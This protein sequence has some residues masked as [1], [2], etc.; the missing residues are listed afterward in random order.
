MALWILFQLLSVFACDLPDLPPLL[1]YFSPSFENT[2]HLE[3]SGRFLAPDESL[4]WDLALAEDSWIRLS[5]EPRLH[6]LK[7]SILKGSNTMLTSSAVQEEFLMISNKLGKG[8]YVIIVTAMNAI[9][10]DETD[11]KN[12]KDCNLPNLFF[13]IAVHPYANLKELLP[14]SLE[15][16]AEGFPDL[17]DVSDTLQSFTPYSGTHSTYILDTSKIEM[18]DSVL[19]TFE[20]TNPEISQELK[21][22]GLTGLWKITFSLHYDFLT[23]GGMGLLFSKSKTN[24]TKFSKLNC[25]KRGSCLFGRRVDK[26]AVTVYSGFGAGKFAITV[27]Y[28]GMTLAEH[29]ML[30][31]LGGKIPFSLHV[32]IEPIIQREDRFNCE[33]AHI[34]HSLNT[35]GLMD[36]NGFLRYSDRVIADFLNVKQATEFEIS[37]PSVLRVITVEP[38]GID[39]DISLK[40]SQGIEIGKSN[41]IGESEGILKELQP[42]KYSIEFGVLNSVINDPR[43]KFCETF[44]LE[45]GISPNEAVRGFA[46]FLGM[47]ACEDNTSDL[48]DKFAKIGENLNST[49]SKVDL[50]STPGDFFRVPLKSVAKGEEVVFQS[51]FY[52]PIY[53]YCYFDIYSDF[54]I[55]DFTISLEKRLPRENTEIVKGDTT[56][57]LKLGKHDRRS[58]QGALAPGTYI[59]SIK[60][61]PTSKEISYTTNDYENIDS[62]D[63]YK[64]LPHCGAFQLRGKLVGTTET[65]LKKWPCFQEDAQLFPPTLNTLDKLGVKDTPSDYL[66][67][68]KVFIPNMMAPNSYTNATNDIAFY[69]NSESFIR[70]AAESEGS[71]MR[72]ALMMGKSTVI[73]D[74]APGERDVAIYGFNQILKQHQTYRLVISYY[75]NSKD[76]CHTYSLLIE[77]APISAL[78]AGSSQNCNVKLPGGEIMTERFLEN[79]GPIL[80]GF[81]SPEGYSQLMNENQYE[82]LQSAKP[83]NIEIP[84]KITTDGALLTGHI[85]SDFLQSGLIL[86]VLKEKEILEYGSF[87]ASHRFELPAFPLTQGEYTLVLK[88]SG[89]SLYKSCVK[90]S[91][92]IIVEDLSLWDDIESMI[93]KSETCSYVDQPGSLNLVGQIQ[94]GNLHWHKEL[95]LDVLMGATL[96]DFVID[97]ESIIRVFVVPQKE[98]TFEINLMTAESIVESVEKATAEEFSSGLH[99]KIKPGSYLLEISY[100]S[101]AALPSRRLCPSFEMDLQIISMT[102]FNKITS[103]YQCSGPASLPSVFDAKTGINEFSIMHN[104]QAIDHSIPLEF[105]KDSE[106]EAIV[107]FENA[108]SGFISLELSN[109]NGVVARSLGIEN[110]SELIVDLEKGSYILHIISSHGVDIPNACWP[111][112]VSIKTSD[113]SEE[114]TCNGGELPPSLTSKHSKVFGGPQARDGSISFHGT[115]KIKDEISSEVLKIS[116]P[117]SGIAR[118]MTISN[119]PKVIIESAVYRDS[120]FKDPVA[121]SRNKSNIGSYIFVIKA[122]KTPYYLLLTYIKDKIEDSCVT[123]DLKIVIETTEEVENILKCKVTDHDLSKVLPKSS[124]DFTKEKE[125]YG[126]DNYVI[127]DKWMIGEKKSFP[128]GITSDGTENSNFMYEM[129]INI[130][131]KAIVSIESTYDFLTNDLNMVLSKDDEQISKS[132]W[133]SL[134][135]D[136]TGELMNFASIIENE[137]LEP[138]QYKLVLKQ[139]VASNHLIQRYKDIDSCFPFSFNIEYIPVF[140]EKKSSS[141]M[142]TLADPGHL[143]HHNPNEELTILI[144]FDSPIANAKEVGKLVSLES[145]QYE[146]IT[147]GSLLIS[148]NAPNKIKFKFDASKLKESTC[149]QLKIDEKS[150]TESGFQL[151]SDGIKHSYCTMSCICN[152]KA[153]AICNE[154]FKCVCPE[155]YTGVTCHECVAG[156]TPSEGLCIKD[157]I[158]EPSTITEVTINVSSPM[159]KDELLNIFVTFSSAPHNSQKNKI[160]AVKNNKVIIDS[161]YIIN[162]LNQK[163]AKASSAAP[164]NKGETKWKFEFD[165]EDLAY[166]ASYS[167][168]IAKGSLFDDEGNEFQVATSLPQFKVEQKPNNPT[169]I[170]PSMNCGPNGRNAILGKCQCDEGYAGDLCDKCDSSYERN[171]N[172]KCE[173]IKAP[174]VVNPGQPIEADPNAIVISITPEG[175]QTIAEDSFSVAIELSQQAYTNEGLIID[176]LTNSDIIAKAFVLQKLKSKKFIRPKSAASLDKKGLRWEFLFSKADLEAD[177]TYKFVQV[178]GVLY[179]NKGKIFSA[180]TIVPPTF[181][182]EKGEEG[183]TIKCSQHGKINGSICIC[184]EGYTGDGCYD[185]DTG[186]EKTSQ[187]SCIM[188]EIRKS[189]ETLFITNENSIWGTIFYCLGYLALGLSIL[190]LINKYRKGRGAPKYENIEMATR[191]QPDEEEGID[192]HSTR[193]DNLRSKPNIFDD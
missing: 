82:F 116:T 89:K 149:Y 39:I 190:Y 146:K 13:N 75:P 159:K 181:V 45:I 179:T 46:E 167:V 73:S 153:N 53:A 37:K 49:K 41:A 162:D 44:I 90:F 130:P 117:K 127:F 50:S 161:V 19:N 28:A 8:N 40:N 109:E 135:D 140:E 59:F 168:I 171:E 154:A 124:I 173:K 60:S 83:L 137:E 4:S 188:T 64:V 17:S 26:N 104:S 105:A 151:V 10:S 186:Y 77:I 174:E 79:T 96:F 94:T 101:D 5:A 107:A 70:V 112:Q 93:R 22:I 180:P 192:I 84:F 172:N 7:I 78:T 9:M 102:E 57:S 88:E 121:Y 92:S 95:E 85:Q 170:S 156:F 68:T 111:L 175:K 115:F 66:P 80:F 120:S 67:V 2:K 113:I 63:N 30:N 6:D 72:V 56:D 148:K 81:N 114:L 145:D 31:S 99:K 36:D 118:I 61:G 189:D 35:P 55:N 191:N 103:I 20:F 3:T 157:K 138:G 187:N 54:V 18:G 122:Q 128:A 98:I 21:D 134:T 183:N 27:F 131:V 133:E 91:T 62:P 132:K 65:K 193:F 52:L 16:Y 15:N 51:T 166:G 100:Y 150:Q 23:G 155:P 74:G 152:P 141:Y 97:E 119:N 185:C 110:Y 1:S 158:D 42:G 182:I 165:S 58:F 139:A 160:T 126:S 69:L 76:A 164:L 43:H 87:E 143:T 125:M 38:S 142:V 48:A 24:L 25:V 123:Y 163:I 106:F 14:K 136:E 32:N 34:P 108:L 178:K 86:Q 11:Q 147:A 29:D 47:N 12:E 71:P 176:K 33:A 184:N 177:A 169:I 129:T 144:V